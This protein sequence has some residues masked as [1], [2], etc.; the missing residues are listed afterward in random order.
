M[1]KICK[2]KQKMQEKIRLN[3]QRNKIE[4]MEFKGKWNLLS[5]YVISSRGSLSPSYN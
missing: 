5:A 2:K 1:C 4:K 3:L